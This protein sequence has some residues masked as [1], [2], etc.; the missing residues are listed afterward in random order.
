MIQLNLRLLLVAGAALLAQAL[1]SGAA[2]SLRQVSATA[3]DLELQPGIQQAI[4][5]QASPD[6]PAHAT[7]LTSPEPLIGGSPPCGPRGKCWVDADL[8]LW[9]IKGAHLPPL[10]VEGD[11]ALIAQGGSVVY[12]N[13]LA[14]DDRRMGARI[15]AG[16]WLNDEQTFG[17]EGEFFVLGTDDDR[18]EANST[19]N[20]FLGRPYLSLSGE[21]VAWPVAS[22]N[23]E[24]GRI[25]VAAESSELIGAGLLARCNVCCGRGYRLDA[26]AGYR[27][28]HFSDGIDIR[29]DEITTTPLPVYPQ[30]T[31]I[32]GED[33][34]HADNLFHGLDL[35]LAGEFRW[36]RIVLAGLAKIAVGQ[37]YQ[38]LTIRGSN[39]VTIFDQPLLGPSTPPITTTVAGN[40][41]T[42]L[43]NIGTYRQND[44]TVVPEWRLRLGWQCKE[45]LRFYA[46]YTL[47]VWHDV[48]RAADQIDPTVATNF[49]PPPAPSDL[50]HFSAF[51]P[52]PRF[53]ASTMWIQ[54]LD[55]G[56]EY[57][58]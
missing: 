8:L 26:I 27:F 22:P 21:H 3:W 16:A 31:P 7:S 55:L 53:D 49:L 20:P 25:Q 36:R 29:D 35:G 43:S 5:Q 41:L 37:N 48:I 40:L 52:A 24:V 33:H 23:L 50:G 32:A 39:T 10:V 13:S 42:Q 2:P 17:I 51:R 1:A 38:E 30:G 19:G 15:T 57:R 14:N 58:F 45:C 28:L 6:L 34:F 56:L 18:F 11:P 47:I 4:E 9:W 44:F 12:G 54:G 46:G